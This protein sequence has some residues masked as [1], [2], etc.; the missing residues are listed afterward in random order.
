MMFE[1]AT[2]I[3]VENWAD[4]TT[5]ITDNTN[6]EW[7]TSGIQ[8][9]TF[10]PVRQSLQKTVARRCSRICWLCS[11]FFVSFISLISAPIMITLFVFYPFN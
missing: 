3:D 9:Q 6:E 1:G 4:N 8:Q 7:N 2:R 5:V 11:A 10:Q